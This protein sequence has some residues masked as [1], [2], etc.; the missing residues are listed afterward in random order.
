MVPKSSCKK[1]KPLY[2]CVDQKIKMLRDFLNAKKK[3]KKIKSF[4]CEKKNIKKKKIL[5]WY[6]N[7]TDPQNKIIVSSTLQG[8][9]HNKKN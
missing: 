6:C 2:H 4:Y 3:K 1:N 8:E 7:R 5:I 9:H